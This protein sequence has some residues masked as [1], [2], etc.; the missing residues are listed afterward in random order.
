MQ[1]LRKGSA[2]LFEFSIPTCK[3]GK[4][5][6]WFELTAFGIDGCSRYD[7]SKVPD[8]YDSAK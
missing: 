6:D 1:S 5:C 3:P 4:A 8:I 7:I 2:V